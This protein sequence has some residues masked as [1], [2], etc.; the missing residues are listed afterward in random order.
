MD[1]ILTVGRRAGEIVE[2]QYADAMRAVESGAAKHVLAA[3]APVHASASLTIPAQPD[4][5]LAPPAQPSATTVEP[6]PKR[7]G[8]PRKPQAEQS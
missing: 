2:M 6:Q 1:V 5:P 8:R 7:R 4:A 3:Q